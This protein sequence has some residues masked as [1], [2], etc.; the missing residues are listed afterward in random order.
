MQAAR[1]WARRA[2]LAAMRASL[3][4]RSQ[5]MRAA[6][7]WARVRCPCR[8]H[9]SAV[10]PWDGILVGTISAPVGTARAGNSGPA[11]VLV[12]Y[13]CSVGDVHTTVPSGRCLSSQPPK[14][15]N[16]HWHR[17]RHGDLSFQDRGRSW[18]PAFTLQRRYSA[19]GE[20]VTALR[21]PH[22][23]SPAVGGRGEA[24]HPVQD[25]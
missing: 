13:L 4:P 25:P 17:L 18:C 5:A 20:G 15:L 11:P 1:R 7:S 23:Y 24:G 2:A 9:E 10:S 12:T 6:W 14:V 22:L 3:M 16:R 21:S 8:H 19:R